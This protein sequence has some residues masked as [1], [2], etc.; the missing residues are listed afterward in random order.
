ALDPLA[1]LVF[2]NSTRMPVAGAV[3][4]FPGGKRQHLPFFLA[5]G[6]SGLE[7]ALDPLAGLVFFNSTRMPVAGAVTIFPGGK[8]QH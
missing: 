5:C 1:G 2:F 4:I 3:T 8:R 7:P 6:I